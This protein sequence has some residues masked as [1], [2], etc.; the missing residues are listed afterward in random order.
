MIQVKNLTK[1]YNSKAALQDV[2]FQAD[3][4]EVVGILGPNGAGKTTLLRILTAYLSP[5]G[6]TATVAGYDVFTHSL[7]VRKRVGY[8]PQSVSL[9]PDMTVAHY[10]DYVAALRKVPNRPQRVAETLK[11]MK[12]ANYADTL[13]GKLP[14]GIHQRV[15]FAQAI[16]HTPK[17][18][19]LDEPTNGLEPEHI[20][21]T[22]E[23]IKQLGQR[24]TIILSTRC[25]PEAE[26]L[27]SRVLLLNSGRVVAQDTP[28]RL[29][30]R[31]EGGHTIRLQLLSAP[32][33]AANILQT[34]DGVKKISELRPGTFDI[35]CG[36]NVD[37]R[38]AV[39][40]LVVQ[41]GWE[42]LELQVV[43]VSLEDVFV[44][45]TAKPEVVI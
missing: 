12:L 40:N 14:A 10:L 17:V 34:L 37:C 25:L 19:I 33:D 26:Q 23:F 44:E 24:H 29:A 13:I 41:K 2:S 21:E 22:R 11:Q 20:I 43:Y 9:Y 42:L 5:S 35:E 32:P 8:L 28:N 16:I 7:E 27:C 36:C 3:A 15:G 39:A 45:L 30:T 18:L 4:G 38:P 31:L 1:Y 6:G